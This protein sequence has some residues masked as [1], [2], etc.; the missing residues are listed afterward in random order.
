MLSDY[1]KKD[2]YVCGKC[3]TPTRPHVLFFDEMYTE[4]HYRRDSVL[5]DLKDCEILIVVGTMLETNLASHIVEK[6]I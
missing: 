6:F 2:A 5:E 3:G 4:E 1:S